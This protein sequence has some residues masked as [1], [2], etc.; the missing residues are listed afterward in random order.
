M[1]HSDGCDAGMTAAISRR[2]IEAYKVKYPAGA[3]DIEEWCAKN[4]I[5]IIG[6]DEDAKLN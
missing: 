4:E 6:G 2:I 3:D 1:G 5:M